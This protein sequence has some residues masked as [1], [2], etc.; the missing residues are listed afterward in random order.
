[1][2]YLRAACYGVPQENVLLT[3]VYVLKNGSYTLRHEEVLRAN[4]NARQDE[5]YEDLGKE[6]HDDFLT[7][8]VPNPEFHGR[9]ATLRFETPET[10]WAEWEELKEV[11]K[12]EYARQARGT[13]LV[14][15]VDD[16]RIPR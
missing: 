8:P 3:T 13:T 7:T 4:L 6:V 12:A 11:L 1:M 5:I 15:M 16:T 10:F 2:A 14:W 9:Y